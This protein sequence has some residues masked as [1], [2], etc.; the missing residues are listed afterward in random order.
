MGDSK[1]NAAYLFHGQ[2]YIYKEYN[3]TDRA[4]SQ[5]G[6]LLKNTAWL[7]GTWFVF[8]FS[9]TMAEMHYLPLAHNVRG[10]WWYGSRCWTSPTVFCYI[11]LLC[12]RWQQR[13]SLTKWQQKHVIEL[14]HVEDIALIDILWPLLN[15]CG[16]QTVDGSTV[17]QW[18]QQCERQATFQMAMQIFTTAIRRLL[19]IAGK[20]HS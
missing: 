8:H 7:S 1:S 10:G 11:L 2:Y 12:N 19:C 4:K 18:W 5:H 3:N 17:R 20:I 9:S 6:M 15:V 13:G 16:E 14:L